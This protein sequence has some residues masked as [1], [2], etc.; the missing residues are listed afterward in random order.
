MRT[1]V[2]SSSGFMHQH[3]LNHQPACSLHCTDSM[4]HFLLVHFI[5]LSVWLNITSLYSF[6]SSL[7]KHQ[8]IDVST[9]NFTFLSAATCSVTSQCLS[10]LSSHVLFPLPFCFDFRYRCASLFHSFLTLSL[11]LCSTV[12]WFNVWLWILITLWSCCNF[13]FGLF[14]SP[15]CYVHL[16]KLIFLNCLV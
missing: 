5:F 3:T 9:Q 16:I 13:S 12:E 2:V 7:S 10:L 6:H 11:W 1:E 14:Y 8:N 15:S 4:T